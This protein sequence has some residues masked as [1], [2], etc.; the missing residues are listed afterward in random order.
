MSTNQS[1]KNPNVS[2]LGAVKNWN[3]HSPL[4]RALRKKTSLK[5]IVMI[6]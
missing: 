2:T 5:F 6:R 4:N 3:G 1:I